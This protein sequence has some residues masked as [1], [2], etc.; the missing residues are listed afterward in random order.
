MQ[1]IGGYFGLE[2]KVGEHYHKEAI[3]LNTARNCFEY[4]L[5]ARKYAKVYIPYYTCEVLLEPLLK[6]NINYVF[7]HINEQLEPVNE[8]VLNADEAFL[9]TNYFGVKQVAVERLAKL[10]NKQLIVDNAQ[11]FYAKPIQGIDTFYSARKFFGVPDGAYLYTDI[12]IEV[13]EQDVSYQRMSHL[14]KRI[15]L[16]ATAGYSDFQTND[17]ALIEQPI[18]KMSKLTESLLSAIDYNA[19]RQQRIDNYNQLDIALGNNNK[20][21]LKLS[22]NEVPMVYAYY[23]DDSAL[24]DK[25]IKNKVFVATYWPNVLNWTKE[26]DVEYKFTENTVFLPVDQRYATKEIDVILKL[27]V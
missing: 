8:I 14:L 10:Y 2:L 20:L 5:R 4:I 21:R 12:K 16:G 17:A 27:L 11:A 18:L 3:R 23:T 24:K 25:L 1:E 6:L 26:Q 15:D 7:Y 13:A 22:E 19:A 9:Y